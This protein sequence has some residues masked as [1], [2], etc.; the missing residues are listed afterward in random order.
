MP[1]TDTVKILELAGKEVNNY[2][3]NFIDEKECRG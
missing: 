2:K 1:K 3:T